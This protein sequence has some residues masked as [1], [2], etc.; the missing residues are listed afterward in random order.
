MWRTVSSK[1][2]PMLGKI[3]G[4]RRRGQQ[5]IR[6]L[7]GI[8]D[9]T[10]MSLSKLRE[11]VMDREACSPWGCR[12][13]REWATELNWTELNIISLFSKAEHKAHTHTCTHIHTYKYM[14]IFQRNIIILL[15]LWIIS[16]LDMLNNY[17]LNNEKQDIILNNI[18]LIHFIMFSVMCITRC[19]L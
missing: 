11:L 3:E 1:K 2:T 16:I 15:A 8:T 18:K 9:S 5:R 4:R 19:I 7:D 12:V 14:L 13:R 6:W 17:K 10:D